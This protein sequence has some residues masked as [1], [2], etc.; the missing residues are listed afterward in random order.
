MDSVGEGISGGE[1]N[2]T[3]IEALSEGRARCG[4]HQGEGSLGVGREGAWT[5]SGE[6]ARKITF[7]TTSGK[8]AS[9]Q[10]ERYLRETAELRGRTYSGVQSHKIT[11]NIH[12]IIVTVQLPSGRI[13]AKGRTSVHLHV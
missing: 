7:S 1:W 10:R 12:A 2:V 6:Q 9:S 5:S 8:I 13:T 4:L 11:T 3:G